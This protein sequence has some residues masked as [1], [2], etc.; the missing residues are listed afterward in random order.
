MPQFGTLKGTPFEKKENLPQQQNT[1]FEAQDEDEV[2]KPDLLIISKDDPVHIHVDTNQDKK[3]TM[4]KKKDSDPNELQV[5]NKKRK[6]S[7]MEPKNSSLSENENSVSVGKQNSKELEGFQEV[8]SIPESSLVKKSTI[9]GSRS[10]VENKR[11]DS[12]PSYFPT[13][14]WEVE[15]LKKN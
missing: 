9:S 5:D 11:K 10:Q 14:A 12:T 1:I 8:H 4:S 2:G 3:M 15:F 6:V 13:A 7:F